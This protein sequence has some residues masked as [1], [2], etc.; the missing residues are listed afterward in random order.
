M[1]VKSQRARGMSW[2][3]LMLLVAV[4]SGPA[5]ASEDPQN[6]PI[7]ELALVDSGRGELALVFTIEPG[8]HI[9]WQNPGDSGLPTSAT[10]EPG[11]LAPLFPGPERYTSKDGERVTY[12]YSG[13]VALFF[14]D[15]RGAAKQTPSAKAAWLACRERCVF[16]EGQAQLSEHSLDGI[17][18]LRSR[19]PL[20][21]Q[22]EMDWAGA[23]VTVTLPSPAAI[24]FPPSALEEQLEG[25]DLNGRNLHLR[26]KDASQSKLPVVVGLDDGTFVSFQLVPPSPAKD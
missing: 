7:V 6:D 18:E 9:Y 14:R 26:L 23:A 5:A 19:V 13:R 21:I 24:L 1:F 10:L 16:Q 3:L 20:E 15:P 2:C 11:G 25:H 8:W 4:G 17:S 22:P 12:G